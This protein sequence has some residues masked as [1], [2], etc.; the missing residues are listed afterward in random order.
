MKKQITLNNI[1]SFLEGYKNMFLLQLG[2]KP[3]WFKEQVAYRM[4]ACANDC[5]IKRECIKCGCSIPAK[6][7]IEQSCNNERFPDIM[8]EQEWINFKK[9]NGIR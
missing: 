7:M 8:N 9:L 6:M 5:M 3:D 2:T 4:S 1:K